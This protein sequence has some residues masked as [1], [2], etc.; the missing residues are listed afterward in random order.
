[1]QQQNLFVPA[2]ISTGLL[3][4][5]ETFF[6]QNEGVSALLVNRTVFEEDTDLKPAP[7]INYETQ[8]DPH[9]R[10][11]IPFVDNKSIKSRK[12]D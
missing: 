9:Q 1:M 4:L 7:H 3:V 5:T 10:G 12:L 11:E 6:P 2:D 8:S